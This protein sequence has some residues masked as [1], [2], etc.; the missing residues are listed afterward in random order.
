MKRGAKVGI[1]LALGALVVLL[2]VS[3]VLDGLLGEFTIL[4]IR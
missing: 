1:V 2:V 3:G 4:R